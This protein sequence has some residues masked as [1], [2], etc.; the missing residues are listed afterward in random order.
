[1]FSLTLRS[2]GKLK[3]KELTSL[4][5]LENI[6]KSFYD[7]TSRLEILSNIKLHVSSGS[8]ISIVGPSGS[9][10]STLLHIMSGIIRPDS[11]KVYFNNRDIYELKEY[12]RSNLRRRHIGFVFQDFKLLPYY[13]VLD[14]VKLPIYNKKKENELTIRA[15]ELL[16]MVGIESALFNRLPEGLSGGEKQRVAIARSLIANP[17]VLIC[18]EP[19]GNLDQK[20]R[21]HVI[22]LLSG[23]KDQGKTII[24]V[25]HD[26]DA[27]ERG[28]D[29]YHLINRTLA[30]NEVVT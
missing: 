28:D 20:N 15:K 9:G 27:A 3:H 8:W 18:D 13:S 11:G 19:T 1:M 21:D 30:L 7:K 5:K 26:S 25:T 24:L 14:N 12:E 17:E 2:Q 22:E 29:I 6:N 10:K 16:D 4:I 23:L